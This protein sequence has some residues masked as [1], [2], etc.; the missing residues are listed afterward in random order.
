[1][2]VVL[3][4]AAN[5]GMPHH[6]ARYLDHANR[7][8]LLGDSEPVREFAACVL[9]APDECAPFAHGDVEEYPVRFG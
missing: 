8:A 4:L 1:M 9:R 2:A 7:A 3:K 5:P 6:Q